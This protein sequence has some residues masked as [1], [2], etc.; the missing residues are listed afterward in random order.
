MLSLSPLWL[1]ARRV[2][3]VQTGSHGRPGDAARIQVGLRDSHT[4]RPSMTPTIGPWNAGICARIVF[5]DERD[6]VVFPAPHR[7]GFPD[8][9]G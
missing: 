2:L 6:L 4:D 3:L 8:E 5:V 1:T 7:G 9:N